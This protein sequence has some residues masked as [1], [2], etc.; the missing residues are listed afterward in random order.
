MLSP[1]QTSSFVTCVGQCPTVH[2]AVSESTGVTSSPSPFQ[3]AICYQVRGISLPDMPPSASPP[4][5]L[6]AVLTPSTTVVSHPVSCTFFP[7][8]AR[9]PHAGSGLCSERTSLQQQAADCPPGHEEALSRTFE[10]VSKRCIPLLGSFY[11]WTV[12]F[13]AEPDLPPLN[14]CSSVPF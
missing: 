3:N 2:L 7:C 6:Q 5:A 13:C 8:P 11:W 12:C 10:S 1:L 9:V 14:F 4:A